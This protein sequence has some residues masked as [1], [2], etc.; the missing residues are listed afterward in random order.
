MYPLSAGPVRGVHATYAGTAALPVWNKK[1]VRFGD[2]SARCGNYS[3]GRPKL[4]PWFAWHRARYIVPLRK[5]RA[6]QA[7][8]LHVFAG[9]KAPPI[10]QLTTR[11]SLLIFPPAISQRTPLAVS[12]PGRPAS[13]AFCPLSDVRAACACG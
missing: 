7:V 11:N 3:F 4:A 8:P 6:R 1:A 13:S 5:T 12:L 2:L 9:L 10:P